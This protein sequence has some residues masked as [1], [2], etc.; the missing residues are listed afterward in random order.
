M[1]RTI[2]RPTKATLRPCFW[3]VSSTCCTRCTWL[4]NDA[5]MTRL[6]ACANTR[7]STGDDVALR[8]GEPGH[9][10]VGGVG[11][12]QVDAL[13]AEPRERA[14]V[15]QPAVER[16]LVHLEVAGV[17]HQ[18]GRGADRHRERVR[19][20]VVDRDELAVERP[21]LL[22]VALLHLEGV[23]L[24]PVLLQL[25]LDHG[26]RQPG[27][28][29]RDVGL[30]AQQ[31]RHR[32]DVVLVGVRQHDAVDQVEAVPDVVEVGQDQVDAGLEVLGEQHAAVDDQQPAGVLEDRHVAA[33]LAEA[34]EGDDAQAA[35]R[36]LGRRPE[37]GVRV[38]HEIRSRGP[39]ADGPPRRR[40]RPAAG[41]VRCARGSPR[42]AAARPSRGSRPART[43]P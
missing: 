24:D 6:R 12:Q 37:L 18:A 30:L 20:G 39:R 9:L 35:L 21:D 3:A 32:A 15:G 28:D 33:D 41:A 25:G 13:V 16:Q 1:L 26:Q 11:Q 43:G 31:V 27:P 36:Q 34:A 19:D 7:S 2:D 38:A 8:G 4:A 29:H 22:A 17:Q 5:T 14:Q 42:R 40:W 10:G 23:G